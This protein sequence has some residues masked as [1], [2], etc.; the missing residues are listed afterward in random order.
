M[1]GYEPSVNFLPRAPSET[2]REWH[3]TRL[4]IE[5][6]EEARRLA[7]ELEGW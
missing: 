5:D 2:A 7:R 1:S 3:R 4:R 6:A